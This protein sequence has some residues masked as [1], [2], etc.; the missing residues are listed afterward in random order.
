MG[1]K[2]LY[3]PVS[4]H[5]IRG[6]AEYCGWQFGKITQVNSEPDR[7]RARYRA[8]I[9]KIPPESANQSEMIQ[10]NDLDNCFAAD[11]RPHW[12]RRTQKGDLLVDIQVDLHPNSPL[13]VLEHT[14]MEA[15]NGA[16]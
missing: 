4:L 6:A 14:E 9:V 11:I 12:L 7:G 8:E 16:N 5:V 15:I 1:K 2:T 3:H 13:G 10:L